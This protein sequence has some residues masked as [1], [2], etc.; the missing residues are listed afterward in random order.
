MI[1]PCVLTA[2]LAIHVVLAGSPLVTWHAP[3]LE[4]SALE[5]E[6]PAKTP[7]APAEVKKQSPPTLD[8]LLGIKP[9]TPKAGDSKRQTPADG[10]AGPGDAAPDR[11]E[12]ELDHAL[13]GDEINDA[14]AAAA[15]LMGDASSRLKDHQD[16]GVHTQ[17]IQEDIV[18]KLDL[19]LSSMQNNQQQS[20]S[21]SKSQKKSDQQSESKPQAQKSKS[22]ST[23]S[24]TSNENATAPARQ[25]GQLSPAIESARAAWGSLPERVRE[26]LMQGTSDRFSS[27]YQAMTEA[28]YKRLAEQKDQ[29]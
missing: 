25:D 15:K 9:E 8:E 11:A 5:P 23:P 6:Q 18:R 21:Q 16:A 13:S 28:Y 7:P 4:V 22:Q 27:R 10:R 3:S 26:L 24:S 14:F 17:R 19:V 1:V 2:T 29:K 20:Q 12:G